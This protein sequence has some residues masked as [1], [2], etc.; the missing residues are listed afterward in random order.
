MLS[1]NVSKM[2]Q[3]IDINHSIVLKSE[4]K[5]KHVLLKIPHQIYIIL[6]RHKAYHQYIVC[7]LLC[8]EVTIQTKSFNTHTYHIYQVYHQ[9][10][11]VLM[12]RLK[13][14]F[15]LNPPTHISHL[16]GLSPVCMCSNVSFEVTIQTKSF[17]TYHIYQVYHQYVF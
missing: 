9:Y 10:A 15:K 3:F 2:F 11:C 1:F 13:L 17:N 16:S 6:L 8:L 7:V 5:D 12:C 4:N 14:Q